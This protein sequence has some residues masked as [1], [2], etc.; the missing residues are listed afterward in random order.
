[1]ALE[2]TEEPVNDKQFW[3]HATKYASA[4]DDDEPFVNEIAYMMVTLHRT[5]A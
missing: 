3:H 5:G 4:V 2:I 1:M